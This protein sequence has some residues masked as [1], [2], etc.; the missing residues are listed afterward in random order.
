MAEITPLKFLNFDKR[1]FK[2]A[3]CKF[4]PSKTNSTNHK[5]ADQLK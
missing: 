4:Q 1:T 5:I 2:S 3:R